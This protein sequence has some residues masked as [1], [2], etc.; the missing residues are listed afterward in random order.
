MV[1]FKILLEIQILLVQI[2]VL[3]GAVLVA[4]AQEAVDLEVVHPR[5]VEAAGQLV[6]LVT[7]VLL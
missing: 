4:V 3:E 7:Q 1:V 2:V 6:D 5:D